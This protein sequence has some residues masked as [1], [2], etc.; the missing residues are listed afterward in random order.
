MANQ[1]DQNFAE[2]PEIPMGLGM[3]LAQDVGM[4]DRFAALP[5]EQK[6]Q[7]I[8]GI[9]SIRSKKEMQAYVRSL[10]GTQG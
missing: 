3:A 4:M 6:R 9:H 1:K 7:V 5:E 10:F 2:G 8:E